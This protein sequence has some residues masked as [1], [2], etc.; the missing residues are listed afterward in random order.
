MNALANTFCATIVEHLNTSR[1]KQN[2]R[3]VTHGIFKCIFLDENCLILFQISLKYASS[4]LINKTPAYNVQIMAWRR[5]G[6]KLLFEPT[7]AQFT[8]EHMRHSA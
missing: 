7:M 4:G 8:N 6:D 1:Q 5:T 2:G 3:Q